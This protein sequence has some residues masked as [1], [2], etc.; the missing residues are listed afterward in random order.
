M[1]RSAK[2]RGKKRDYNNKL[3]KITWKEYLTGSVSSSKQ[4]IVLNN[5]LH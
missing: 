4:D 1:M 2:D 5:T 3:D